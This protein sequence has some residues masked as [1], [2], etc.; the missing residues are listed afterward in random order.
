MR[1][2]AKQELAR[3]IRSWCEDISGQLGYGDFSRRRE[4]D[5]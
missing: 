2:P 5:D 1:S 4:P 3:Q